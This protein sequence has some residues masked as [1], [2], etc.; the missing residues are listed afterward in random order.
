MKFNSWMIRVVVVACA[1]WAS[2]AM[3]G[4]QIYEP[5][6]ES[7]RLAMRTSLEG[8]Q[9]P[10]PIFD[11]APQRIDWLSTMSARLAKKAPNF[12][13]RLELIKTIRYEAQRAGLDPQL[14]FAV[15]EVESG[16]KPK[17]YS[18]AGAIGL[19]QVMPF[20]TTLLGD[21]NPR[22]LLDPRINIRY[23]CVILRHYLD[24]ERGNVERALQRYNGSL[25]RS[26]YSDLVLGALRHH[27]VY[28]EPW[29]VKQEAKKIQNASLKKT[30][31]KATLASAGTP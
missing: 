13:W 25:G 6:A 8:N 29:S 7:V 1:L 17:V 18:S 11:S 2:S 21:G 20:W 10:Y 3:A 27:W 31:V 26:D 5:M 15:I 14:V 22:D 9:V 24:M 30:T 16:F 4:R 28:E 19:M 23:G 12:G